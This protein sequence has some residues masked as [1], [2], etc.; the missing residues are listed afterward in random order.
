MVEVAVAVASGRTGS[1]D[2]A[3]FALDGSRGDYFLCCMSSYRWRRHLLD[4]H[5]CIVS[6]SL[7]ILRGRRFLSAT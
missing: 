2:D 5:F 7:A 3:P 6:T 1:V 4:R